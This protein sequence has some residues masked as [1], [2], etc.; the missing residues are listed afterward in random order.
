MLFAVL[1][2][3]MGHLISGLLTG[4]RFM[5]FK[6]LWFSME[7]TGNGKRFRIRGINPPG[8]CLMYPVKS[9]ADPVMMILGGVVANLVSGMIFIVQG[10]VISEIVFKGIALY[11]GCIGITIGLYNLSLGSKYSDGNTYREIRR[12]KEAGHIYNNIMTIYRYFST[13]RSYADMP[14]LLFEISTEGTGPV[15][16]EMREHIERKKNGCSG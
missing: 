13:G 3:E 14:D 5:S 6:L 7:D 4:Y 2:H 16:D 12:D 10:L 11:L 9:N 15:Y 8:Q 1:I